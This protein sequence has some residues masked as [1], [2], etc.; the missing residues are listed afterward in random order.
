MI[1]CNLFRST[2]FHLTSAIIARRTSAEVFR[3]T[4]IGKCNCQNV[5]QNMKAH[6]I[7]MIWL[8]KSTYGSVSPPELDGVQF[9]MSC[10]LTDT[11]IVLIDVNVLE[12]DLQVLSLA[13]A[14]LAALA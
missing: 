1:T 4:N 13:C 2:S 11:V 10:T 8:D 9:V 6:N 3:N 5:L 7:S 12:F 14:S